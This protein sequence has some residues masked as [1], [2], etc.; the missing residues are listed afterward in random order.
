MQII[1]ETIL[2]K[3]LNRIKELISVSVS[4]FAASAKS[5]NNTLG[6]F[7]NL[8]DSELEELLNRMGIQKVA[9][10]FT[11]HNFAANSVNKILDDAEYEGERAIT[12]ALREFTVDPETGYISIVPIPEFEPVS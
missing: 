5:L 6:G 1:Q 12:T 11:A 8:P 7:W 10:V 3:N 9:E 2:D 4:T